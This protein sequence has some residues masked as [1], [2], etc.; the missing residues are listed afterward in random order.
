MRESQYPIRAPFAL[1]TQMQPQPYFPSQITLSKWAPWDAIPNSSQV[2][3]TSVLFPLRQV[4]SL[5]IVCVTYALDPAS[6]QMIP[7]RLCSMNSRRVEDP[8]A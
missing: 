6:K 7:E 4:F 3:S 2:L 8:I 1:H 5:V